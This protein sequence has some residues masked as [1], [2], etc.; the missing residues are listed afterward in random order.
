MLQKV[1]CLIPVY[2]EGPRLVRTVTLL[3]N[4]KEIDEFVI[5]DD[6]STDDGIAKLHTKYPAIKI[7]KLS[8]NQGKSAAVRVGLAKIRAELTLLVDADIRG[9]IPSEI[10]DGIVVMKKNPK[11]EMLIFRRLQSPVTAKLDR[12]D[13]ML[14]GERVIKTKMLKEVM[15]QQPLPE[16]YEMEVALNQYCIDRQAPAYWYPTQMYNTYKIL[17]MGLVKG[18]WYDWLTIKQCAEYVGWGNYW[19]QMCSFCWNQLPNRL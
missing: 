2:N 12:S 4:V 13:I 14:S 6:G 17:K 3:H 9:L 10:S 7:I 8:H 15:S 11:V 1:T 5:V 16:N 19:N 18:L